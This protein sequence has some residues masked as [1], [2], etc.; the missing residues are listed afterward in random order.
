MIGEEFDKASRLAKVERLESVRQDR[1]R[2]PKRFAP[3]FRCIEERGFDRDLAPFRPASMR[4][5]VKR[6]SVRRPT[7]VS[8]RRPPDTPPA[9]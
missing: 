4:S 5:M 2:L 6:W 8:V 9:F 1:E 7:A 3:L